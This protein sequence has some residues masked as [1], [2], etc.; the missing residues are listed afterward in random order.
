MKTVAIE[1][2][3]I[4]RGSGRPSE[5]LQTAEIGEFHVLKA[6]PAAGVHQSAVSQGPRSAVRMRTSKRL[7]IGLTLCRDYRVGGRLVL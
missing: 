5:V 2:R 6:S 4:S 7:L 1:I 3:P